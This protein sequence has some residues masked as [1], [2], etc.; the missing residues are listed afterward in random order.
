MSTQPELIELSLP[1][2]LG[3]FLAGVDVLTEV[4]DRMALVIG[5]ARRNVAEGG[6]PFAAA[7][8]ERDSGRLVALGVNLVAAERL[9]VLH[10]E[11]VALS[12][13]QRQLGSYDLGRAG[14][15]A[16]ELVTTTAPC[17]MCLGAIP[18]SGVRRLVVGAREEDARAV[19]F[20]EGAK[21]ADW[22]GALASR[23]IS[24]VEDV[25]RPQ[26]A[27][28]LQTYARA[29]GII[30]NPQRENRDLTP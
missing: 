8:F 4:S 13:A 15:A 21:P 18:W 24:T 22:Q 1:P 20:D 16:H 10:A 9:S 28:V 3:P 17:A 5:A 7:V 11:I 2:W 26:A 6:G 19:G 25:L 23:G 27:Q 29:G 14:L 12:L 30:Y